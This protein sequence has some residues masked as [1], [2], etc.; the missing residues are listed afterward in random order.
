MDFRTQPALH[1]FMKENGLIGDADVLS[2]PGGPQLLANDFNRNSKFASEMA[3][4]SV[5]L[6]SV[7][8][9][10]L[11]AH[12]DC[13]AYGGSDAFKSRAVEREAYM[14]DLVDAAAE[15]RSLAPKLNLEIVYKIIVM[16][17]DGWVVI[18][19]TEGD[20]NP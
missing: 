15:I 3:L 20:L 4:L 9:V 16:D 7:R 8:T 19:F 14:T 18:N 12:D 1:R 10:Y 13:M 2:F 6:H 11:I 17:G 5:G